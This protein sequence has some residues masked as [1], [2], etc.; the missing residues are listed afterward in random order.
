[1]KTRLIQVVK[2]DIVIIIKIPKGRKSK[3]KIENEK[4]F[5]QPKI[6]KIQ[7]PVSMK[8]LKIEKSDKEKTPHFFNPAILAHLKVEKF[9]KLNILISVGAFR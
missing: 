6:G 7:N 9:E 3:Q 2:T 1:M 8:N 4:L 5:F